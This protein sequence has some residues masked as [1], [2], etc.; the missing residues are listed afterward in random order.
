MHSPNQHFSF[1][2]ILTHLPHLRAYSSRACPHNM[3]HIRKVTW[4]SSKNGTRSQTMLAVSPNIPPLG[5]LPLSL[6]VSA[7]LLLKSSYYH[8]GFLIIIN[9]RVRLGHL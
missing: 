7:S 6:W 9:E 2:L 4:Y 8:G 1:F 3:K 5:Y